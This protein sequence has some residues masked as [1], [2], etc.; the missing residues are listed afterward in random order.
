V[1]DLIN[2]WFGRAA[3][4]QG[5]VAYGLRYSHG[6]AFSRTWEARLTESVLIEL[7]NRLA[8]IAEAATPDET[9][10]SLRWS[11][12]GGTVIAAARPDGVIFFVL[13]SRKTDD[14]DQAGLNRLLSEFRA[15]RSLT[16]QP[17]A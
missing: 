14:L 5:A 11:F 9:P 16:S 4:V 17:A 7:W 13:T 2:R 6:S 3:R 12:N 10:E 1:S 15:L 8:G